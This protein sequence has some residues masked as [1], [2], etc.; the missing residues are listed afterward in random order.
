MRWWAGLV[1]LL[2]LGC[3]SGGA[4]VCPG[5]TVMATCATAR[6]ETCRDAHGNTCVECAGSGV[7][8]NCIY[9]PSAPFDGGTAVCVSKCSVCGPD[10]LE[11]K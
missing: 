9:D 2:A 4:D 6:L 3:G 11:M 8:D 7:K 1:M 5:A 10:C